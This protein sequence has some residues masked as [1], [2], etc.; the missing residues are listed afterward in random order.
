MVAGNAKGDNFNFGQG[1]SLMVECDDQKQIDA[2]TKKL[3][4]GG[5][6]QQDC[7]W[8]VDRFGV[9]WQIVPKIVREIMEGKDTAKADR[10]VHAL[11]QMKKLD[12][13]ALQRAA[14][15]N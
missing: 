1:L 8:V 14:N 7:G 2:V 4:D 11:F 12:V 6:K 9:S 15:G 10:M 5:A 13:A 3:L